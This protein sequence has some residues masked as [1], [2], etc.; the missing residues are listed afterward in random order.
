MENGEGNRGI[1]E[2][3][4]DSDTIYGLPLIRQLE[5]NRPFR[6]T[7]NKG[8]RR[9]NRGDGPDSQAFLEN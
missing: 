7:G 8:I 2:S 1:Y 5:V 9:S 4:G 3:G 6:K